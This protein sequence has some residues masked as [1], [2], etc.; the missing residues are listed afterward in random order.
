[1]KGLD[2]LEQWHWILP[3]A[4]A[5]VAEALEAMDR[6]QKF[7][8]SDPAFWLDQ[9]GMLARTNRSQEAATAY[10]KAVELAEATNAFSAMLPQALARR[11][12]FLS[13]QGRLVE[14]VADNLRMLKIP[15]RPA[16]A[17]ANLIDLSLH[18]NFP[19]TNGSLPGP[20]GND[21]SALPQGVCSMLGTEFD[22]R[23]FI[24]LTDRNRAGYNAPSEVPGIS[25]MR[26][27][28]QLH[29]FHG[30]Q[31]FE[32]EA[33]LVGSYVIHYADGAKEEL[34]LRYGLDLRDWWMWNSEEPKGAKNSRVAW[35][36]TNAAA[37]RYGCGIRLFESRWPNPRP[38]TE[39][40]SID[41]RSTVSECAPF[42]I[43]ITAE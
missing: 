5:L 39:I 3:Y 32:K 15:P 22:V 23:G 29:F 33:A 16:E 21:L 10:N 31:G 34:S 13:A 42:L 2:R 37:D 18:Y 26:T 7:A 27:C 11:S 24:L 8:P 14:A 1:M 35:T 36:G 40:T 19:L 30:L 4:V 25:I 20:Q 28:R 17:R 12:K 6:A 41:F 9:G 38:E 43:A